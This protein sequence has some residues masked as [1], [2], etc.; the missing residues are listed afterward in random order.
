M[1]NT[2]WIAVENNIVIETSKY[3]M[4]AWVYCVVGLLVLRAFRSL[5]AIICIITPLTMT[6]ILCQA[7]ITYMGI[8]VK[9][10]TLPVIALGVVLAYYMINGEILVNAYLHTLQSTDMADD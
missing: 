10:A 1:G 9:M 7:L 8:G 6:S 5:K 2:T 3:E 4:L